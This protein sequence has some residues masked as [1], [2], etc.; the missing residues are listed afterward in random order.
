MKKSK[1][2][3]H[4]LE[5]GLI[6]PE[7]LEEALTQ[8]E[9]AG[10]RLGTN[11]LELRALREDQLLEALGKLCA[12]RTAS[13]WDLKN[14]DAEIIDMVPERLALRY[15]LVPYALEGKT[16]LLAS[17]DAGNL[18]VEDE[19][20]ALTGCMVRTSMALELRILE[21][22]SNY[23]DGLLAPRT[24]KLLRRLDG[25]PRGGGSGLPPPPELGPSLSPD[26]KPPTLSGPP[27]RASGS[28][29][30]AAPPPPKPV[31]VVNPRPEPVPDAAPAATVA[32]L[33]PKPR[34][35]GALA[36]ASRR[37][38]A[39][40]IRDDIADAVM[41]Y[42]ATVFKRRALLYVRKKRIVGWRGEGEGLLDEAVQAIDI[43][44]T[45]ASVFATVEQT[46]GYWLGPLPQHKANLHL[47]LALGGERPKECLVLPITLRA[48]PIAFLYGDNIDE[49]V[50]ECPIEELR[51]L[52]AKAGLAFEICVLKNKLRRS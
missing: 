34:G 12:T 3:S 1:L 37:L 23:Y 17:K 19:I 6:T 48:K 11:L 51:R 36:R 28:R 45:H 44:E 14:I 24:Q 10:G 15:K 16:L 47:V 27:K 35:E 49:P 25:V 30:P 39:A 9:T 8:K 13:K 21:A 20:R 46:E 2:G 40:E 42:T 41:A 52:A 5:E 33:E 18:L 22:L 38:Q 26:L 50:R 29:P 32:V 43:D 7:V 4:L 31:H